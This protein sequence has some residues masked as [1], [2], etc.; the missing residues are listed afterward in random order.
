MNLEFTTVLSDKPGTIEKLLNQSYADLLSSDPLFWELEQASW[1]QYDQEVFSHKETVGKCIFLSRL[2]G[3]IVGFG[4]WDPRLSPRYGLLG[5]NCIL[6]EFRGKGLGKQQ[7]REILRRFQKIGI[8]KASVTTNDHPFFVPAQSMYI[9]CGFREIQRI[10]W[11][12][13]SKRMLIE[14]EKEIGQPSLSA[15]RKNHAPAEE[16][17]SDEN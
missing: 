13:D 15:E 14:Y 9:A 7:I 1:K 17:V 11:N 4:S 2:N 16:H 8:Q 10:P 12:R 3:L 5:H 6:P